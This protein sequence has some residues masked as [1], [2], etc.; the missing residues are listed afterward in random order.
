M[1]LFWQ[2]KGVF[3]VFLFRR[4]GGIIFLSERCGAAVSDGMPPHRKAAKSTLPKQRFHFAQSGEI[5]TSETVF[6]VLPESVRGG[7]T[8]KKAD[9]CTVFAKMFP[10]PEI[11]V[12]KALTRGKIYIIIETEQIFI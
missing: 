4:R 3:G 1:P 9:F 7:R 10:F 5:Y 12:E 6:P 8:A 11:S 2:E